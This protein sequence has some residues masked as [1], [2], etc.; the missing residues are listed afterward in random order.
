MALNEANN[1]S[2][3]ATP[4]QPA[5]PTSPHD[6]TL[7]RVLG[8]REEDLLEDIPAQLDEPAPMLASGPK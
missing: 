4:P 1:G 8:S 5:E 7:D 2:Q 6:L 3:G